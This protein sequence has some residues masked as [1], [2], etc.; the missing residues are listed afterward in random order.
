L[1]P[2]FS[3]D[4]YDDRYDHHMDKYCWKNL[5]DSRPIAPPLE[6]KQNSRKFYNQ[7]K[8]NVMNKV[9]IKSKQQEF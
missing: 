6:V 7:I 9:N 5:D 8:C 3:R 1:L 4:W 2:P